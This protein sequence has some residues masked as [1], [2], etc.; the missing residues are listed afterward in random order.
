MTAD[1]R[2][3]ATTQFDRHFRFNDF[4]LSDP[5]RIEQR[6][7]LGLEWFTWLDDD[8]IVAS[9]EDR[10]LKMLRVSTD[11]ITPLA[12]AEGSWYIQPARCGPDTLVSTVGIRQGI[13]M[14]IYKM[15]F[16]G[17]AATAVS[18]G[19]HDI[20]P[21][22]SA[23]G[24]WLFYVDNH[25]PDKEVV[26]RMPVAGGPA[27]EI[28]DRLNYARYSLSSDGKL[29][30]LPWRSG[31]PTLELFSTETLR[32]VATI[33][34]PPNA[35]SQIAFSPDNK[36]FYSALSNDQGETIYRQSISNSARVS[37]ETLPMGAASTWIQLSPDGKKLGLTTGRPESKAVL[38]RETRWKCLMESC[39]STMEAPWGHFRKGNLCTL[40]VA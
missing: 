2:T 16:D 4:S 37:M 14:R 15:H 36:S 32:P 24:K 38:L 25:D 10:S 27:H 5:A 8:R 35:G 1:A 12:A 3:I 19:P 11:E 7:P 34:W 23:D 21:T 9:D 31:S 18:P 6:G 28:V 22:C 30:A 26:M 33:P 39:R 17:T 13:L 29:I 20:F 40:T